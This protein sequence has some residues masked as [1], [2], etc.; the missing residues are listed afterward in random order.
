M[1]TKDFL[2]SQKILAMKTKNT[3][4]KNV[5]SLAIG[6][7]NTA[8]VGSTQGLRNNGNIVTEE[9]FLKLNIAKQLLSLKE[10]I[11]AFQKRG[12]VEKIAALEKEVTYIQDT[13]FPPLAEDE[14]KVL[15]SEFKAANPEAKMKDWMTYLRENYQSRYN[16]A[17]ATKLFN[18]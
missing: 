5:V 12:D 13:F 7:L 17:S 18:S 16:G 2:Q 8:S 1:F 6:D 4:M 14:I 15:F 3:A 10:T 11:A 9:T